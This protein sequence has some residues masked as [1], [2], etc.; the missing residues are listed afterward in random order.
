[1][2][3]CFLF[4]LMLITALVFADEYD[5]WIDETVKVLITKEEKD[6]F[7]KLKSNE[8]KD[9]FMADFWAKR[10]PSPGTPENEFK[11]TYEERL[12]TVNDKM[13]GGSKK[14][15]DTDMGKAVLL[16]GNPSDSK[17]EES[18]PPKQTWTWTGLPKEMGI[19]DPEIK[20]EGDP[21]EGGFVFSDPKAA[22]QVLDKARAFL[23]NLQGV[24]QAQAPA[25]APKA[26]PAPAQTGGPVQTAELKAALDATATDNAPKDVQLELIGDSFMTSTGEVFATVA[27]KSPAAQASK[28][29]V[30]IVDASGA[31]VKETELPF[32]SAEE[33]PG[34]FQTH[35]PVEPG[36]YSLAVAIADAGK[37]GGIKRPLSVPDYK[38]KLSI[39]SI[40]FMSEFKQLPDGQG[41]P[42]PTAYT[43]GRTKITPSLDHTYKQAGDLQF[44]YEIY[45]A[46]P[47]ASG[48]VKVENLEEVVRFEKTGANPKQGRPGPPRGFAIAKK[49]T[50]PTGYPL[51]TF[52]PGEYKMIITITDKTS[53]QTATRDTTFTVQ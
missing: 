24:A 48:E 44:L 34:Y 23:S 26:T 50:V 9:K 40:I 15:I 3:K 8:E 5:K 21:D 31:M 11:K 10:D 41:K 37:A 30:R 19:G 47:D 29:G 35:L 43:F 46:Q 1:M 32:T 18:D 12:S 53:G 49:V 6:A 52:Q 39:S 16:L 51:G 33:K 14:A 42:E 27:V 36:E 7:K 45:N 13:K 2:K 4:L 17:T 25:Q 38:S 28:V 20:F 22:N